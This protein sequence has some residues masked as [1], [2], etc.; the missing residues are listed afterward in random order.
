[1]SSTPSHRLAHRRPFGVWRTARG[2]T[3]LELVMVVAVGV[4]MT[5]VAIPLV[6]SSLRSFR[7]SSAV[8]S[9]T[10]AIESTRYRAI[11]DGC[12]YRISFNNATNTYQISSTVT[13]GACAAAY[14]NVG[15]AVS[16]GSTGQVALSQN[17]TFQFSPGGS[18]QTVA[19]APTFTLTYVGTTNLKTITVTKYGSI[20]VQ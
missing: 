1:M 2:F 19:G 6:Q 14:T 7:M 16:F 18:V 12:P 3:T 13:G 8:S 5:A 17:L 10:G 11:F 4:I 9:V 15:G 20:T